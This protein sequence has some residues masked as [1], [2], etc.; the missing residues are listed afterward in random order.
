MNKLQ[1]IL[2]MILLTGCLLSC[3]TSFDSGEEEMKYEEYVF[4]VQLV[5]DSDMIS[6]YLDYHQNIWPEVEAGFKKAGYEEIRLYRFENFV[7]M[8]V[9]APLGSDLNQMG[10][11]CNDSH[12][13]VAEWNQLM[14]GFQKGLPGSQEGQSWAAMEKYYEFIR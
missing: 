14:D 4:A 9:K 12:P 7:T 11:I 6:E 10:K 8:I 5:E 2:S 3:S 1:Y 13:K